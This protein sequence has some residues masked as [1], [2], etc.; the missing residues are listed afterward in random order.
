MALSRRVNKQLT[1]TGQTTGE[2]MAER[3]READW[4]LTRAQAIAMCEE[5][6]LPGMGEKQNSPNQDDNVTSG[7]SSPI[8]N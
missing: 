4:K 1:S 8:T 5:R 7:I 3:G 6:K 2:P